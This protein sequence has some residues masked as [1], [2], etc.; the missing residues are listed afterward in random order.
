MRGALTVPQA[1]SMLLG[2]LCEYAFGQHPS[3]AWHCMGSW[4]HST[5]TKVEGAGAR[6]WQ[7]QEDMAQPRIPLWGEATESHAPPFA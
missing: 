5:Q 4:G 1:V 6:P 3:D 7:S 2:I